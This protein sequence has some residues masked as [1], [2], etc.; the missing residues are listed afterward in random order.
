MPCHPHPKSRSQEFENSIFGFLLRR[1]LFQFTIS[2]PRFCTGPLPLPPST[3]GLPC[4]K[5]YALSSLSRPA[6]PRCLPLVLRLHGPSAVWALLSADLTHLWA[7]NTS[8]T[9]IVMGSDS[10]V[11]G[12]FTT[13]TL[14]RSPA[15][16][17]PTSGWS[18]WPSS[19]QSSSSSLLLKNLNLL[20]VSEEVTKLNLSSFAKICYYYIIKLDLQSIG[21]SPD[22][23]RWLIRARQLQWSKLGIWTLDISLTSF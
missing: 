2:S 1:V 16:S 21:S 4:Y 18:E 17:A 6:Q 13:T 15:S 8:D 11:S 3:R 9:G 12:L 22:L 23:Q 14:L 5:F 20:E 10:A 7:N 19:G